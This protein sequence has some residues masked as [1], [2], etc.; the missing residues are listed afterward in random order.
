M[1][2]EALALVDGNPSSEIFVNIAL[3]QA[4]NGKFDDALKTLNTAQTKFPNDKTIK[5][6]IKNITAMRADNLMDNAAALYNNKKYEDAI[7]IYLSVEPPTVNT[8]LGAATSYQQLGDRD[9][10]I[11]YYKKALELK[12]VDSDIAYYIAVLYG[13]KEDYANAKNYLGKALAFNKN[14]QQA[15]E[16]LKSIEDADMANLL[17]SAIEKYEAEKYDE[18]LPDFNKLLSKNANNDYALRANTTKQ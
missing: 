10:A 16:Y 1:Y 6:N 12:P 2:N 7:R 17:N 13:E 18:A 8:M 5:T 11:V 3:A 4:Q 14:N 15:L 9:N